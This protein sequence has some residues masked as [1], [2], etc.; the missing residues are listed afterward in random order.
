MRVTAYTQDG[1]HVT[2]QGNKHNALPQTVYYSRWHV[3]L[4]GR[5]ECLTLK[6]EVRQDLDMPRVVV[7]MRM[8][9]QMSYWD[10]LRTGM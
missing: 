7:S 4:M 9:F 6:S 2:F 1:I 10:Y 5:L 3:Q 8:F